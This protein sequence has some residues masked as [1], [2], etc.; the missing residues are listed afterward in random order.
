[1]L[2]CLVNHAQVWMLSF[3]TVYV[4]MLRL[5][6]PGLDAEFFYCMRLFCLILTLFL[7]LPKRHVGIRIRGL[8]ANS[9]SNR[10][11]R[12]VPMTSRPNTN[13]RPSTEKEQ[14]ITGILEWRRISESQSVD[15]VIILGSFDCISRFWSY[16]ENIHMMMASIDLKLNRNARA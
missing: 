8:L 12:P 5:S 9:L 13:T 10:T 3:F 7:Q 4:A 11:D 2:Q 6:L 14:L 16:H 1:M 15:I